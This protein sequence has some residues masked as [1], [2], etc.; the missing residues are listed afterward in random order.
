MTNG[1]EVY[2][3]SVSRSVS[4]LHMIGRARAQVVTTVTDRNGKNVRTF[5]GPVS[6]YSAL[7][8]AEI[9]EMLTEAACRH[10]R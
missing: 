7:T 4:E 5:R 1:H 8:D 6:D 2:T 9:D 3:N 10:A